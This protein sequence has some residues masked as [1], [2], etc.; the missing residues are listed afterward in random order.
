MQYIIREYSIC[1][2]F[3]YAKAGLISATPALEKD[4]HDNCENKG[5]NQ[6]LHEL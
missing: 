5:M 6:T 1:N 2:Q 4:R 3:L